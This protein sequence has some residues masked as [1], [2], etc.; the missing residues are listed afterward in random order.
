MPGPWP[1]LRLAIVTDEELIG[2]LAVTAR[3]A[4]RR[5]TSGHLD[6]LSGNVARAES[7]PARPYWDQKAVAHAEVIGM[8]GA[9]TGDPVLKRL[10]GLAVGWIY[11]LA[12]AA[13]PGADGIILGSRRRL[14]Y[15]LRAGDAE[16]AGQELETHL[17]ALTFMARLAR[18]GTQKGAPR[19]A[20]NAPRSAA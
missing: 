5:M 3:I 2:M 6:A 8:L 11:D 19:S 13:G 18:A 12:A 4:C 15:H 16:A 10:A 14:L 7:V 20:P 9:V 1:G 17:R